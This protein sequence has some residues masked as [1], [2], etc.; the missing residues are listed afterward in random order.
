MEILCENCS[1]MMQDPL[2]KSEIWSFLSNALPY[3]F[4]NLEEEY[5]VDSFK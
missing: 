5:L 4:Q 1:D 3:M 2:V